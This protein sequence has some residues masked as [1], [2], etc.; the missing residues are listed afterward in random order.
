MRRPSASRAS[1][2]VAAVAVIIAVLAVT[3]FP[4]ISF[5]QTTGFQGGSPSDVFMLREETPEGCAPIGVNADSVT[6][7]PL[8]IEVGA[9]SHVLA[10]F[11][12]E[13][14]TLAIREQGQVNPE[15]DGTGD[16]FEWRFTG[17]P[18]G[19]VSGTVMSSFPN[20]DPGTHTIDV[21]AAVAAI[22]GGTDQGPLFANLENCVL[23]VFVIP[24]AG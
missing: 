16:A 11:S 21:F 9:A 6:I 15:L 5:G 4:G 7:M 22:P 2:A 19:R 18:G 17:N 20:V 24:S 23:S 12:F 8:Q 13:W 1:A 10:Y 3:G 14:S